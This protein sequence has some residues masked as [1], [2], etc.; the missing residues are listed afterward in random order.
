MPDGSKLFG[1][2]ILAEPTKFFTDDVLQKIDE[3]CKVEFL[4]GT[5]QSETEDVE[6]EEPEESV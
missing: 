1:N 6:R 5:N 2:A 3:Y 4:Y